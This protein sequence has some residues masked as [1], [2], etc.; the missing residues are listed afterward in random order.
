MRF[1]STVEYRVLSSYFS[2]SEELRTWV[3]NNTV[4]AIN[5]INEGNR[6]SEEMHQS[7]EQAMATNDVDLVRMIIEENNIPMPSI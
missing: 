2:Q 3:F 5:W 6:V 4:N 1:N 7:F